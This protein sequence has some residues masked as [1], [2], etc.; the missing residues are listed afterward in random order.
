MDTSV[1]PQALRRAAHRL[2]AAADLLH[3]VL[4]VH[5]GALRF[6]ADAGVRAAVDRLVG[7]IGRWQRAAR[8]TAAS[9]RT[10][11]E[12]FIDSENRAA[13]ALR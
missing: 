9:L 8:E 10:S 1:D 13:Q 4:T 6:D 5:L 7:D 12:H 3:G 11:A 2:D